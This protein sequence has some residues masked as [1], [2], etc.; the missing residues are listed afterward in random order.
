MKATSRLHTAD[1]VQIANTLAKLAVLPLSREHK[2]RYLLAHLTRQVGG[3]CWA[4]HRSQAVAATT[5]QPVTE[6]QWLDGGWASDVALD[7]PLPA[8]SRERTST[9]ARLVLPPLHTPSN[10]DFLVSRCLVRSGAMSQIAIRR[11]AGGEP[12]GARQQVILNVVCQEVPWLHD[13]EDE[14]QAGP[15]DLG[16]APRTRQVLQL[17]QSGDSVKQVAMKLGMSYHT[18]RDHLKIIHRHL[19]VPN[20]A[21]LLARF[22]GNQPA[23]PSHLRP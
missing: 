5:E 12:F 20:R 18:A 6:F 2:R 3:D 15:S 11:D 19:N 14:M 17:I 13:P 7:Q 21:T 4:W 22:L 1:V 8:I 10:G 16:L 9:P 23:R